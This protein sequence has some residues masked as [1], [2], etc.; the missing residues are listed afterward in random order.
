MLWEMYTSTSGML[1]RLRHFLRVGTVDLKDFLL[2]FL[3][4]TAKS[5]KKNHPSAHDDASEVCSISRC[6]APMWDSPPFCRPDS[7]GFRTWLPAAGHALILCEWYRRSS[8]ETFSSKLLESERIIPNLCWRLC[9][10]NRT[11][12]KWVFTATEISVLS[13]TLV[14]CV[15]V[16]SDMNII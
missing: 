11:F 2:P 13:F 16:N 7:V 1:V 8:W 9:W 10:D 6:C 15:P 3:R 12:L 4:N 14:V 5:R